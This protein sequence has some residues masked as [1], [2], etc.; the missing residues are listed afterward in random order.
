MFPIKRTVFLC[1]VTLVK[2]TVRLIGNIEYVALFGTLHTETSDQ[3]N[4]QHYFYCYTPLT[5]GT[6]Y[7]LHT[8]K[9][10]TR[11]ESLDSSDMT[12]RGYTSLWH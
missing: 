5:F 9:C 1:T 11:Q 6:V 12:V 2:N 3:T 8:P 10:M 4:K 7:H